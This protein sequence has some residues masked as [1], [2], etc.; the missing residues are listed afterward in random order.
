M[1]LIPTNQQIINKAI[2]LND[3]I[4]SVFDGLDVVENTRREYKSRIGLFLQFTKKQG[5]NRNTFLE[6]KR[7]LAERADF[8]VST[9]NKYLATARIFLKELN[10][11]GILPVDI[12][13][14]IKSFSQLKKHKKDGFTQEEVELMALYLKEMEQ[15]PRTSRLKAF[16][17]LL[18]LQGLRQI[19]IIRLDVEDI[20]LNNGTAF[21]RGKGRDDKELIYL[22]PQTVNTLKQHVKDNRV[23][24]GALFRSLGRRF[25][26]RIT[27]MTI[28]REIRLLTESLNIKKSVHGFRHY[29]ITTLLGKMDV[30]DVRKFSR[31]RSLEMLIVYDDEMDVKCK[32]DEVQKIFELVTSII[33]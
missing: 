18:A 5:L 31:H 20:N 29:F 33:S 8:T 4:D 24:A 3:F 21:V 19:E 7:Y 12:T 2:V 15:S 22:N 27:T 23:G 6:Y 9:K 25:S 14:N 32:F 26:D 13:Q 11:I 1:D 16:F 17:C 28:K 30:R 10:R